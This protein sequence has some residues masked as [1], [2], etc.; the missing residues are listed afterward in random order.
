MKKV[1]QLFFLLTLFAFASCKGPKGD[2]GVAGAIGSAGPQGIQG[3]MGPVGATGN[4]NIKA[5]IFSSAPTDWTAVSSTSNGIYYQAAAAVA[6]ITQA[7]H[8]KG[9]VLGF[10]SEGS[11][12]SVWIAMPYTQVYKS[13]SLTYSQ[14]YRFSEKVGSI[15][16]TRQDSDGLTLASTTT[17]YFKFVII[18]GA[19]APP[20]N[21]DVNSYQAVKDFY[22]IAD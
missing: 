16:V 9:L 4:A 5:R 17:K 3:Q 6:E 1:F 19:S 8:D 15:T 11:D 20:P 7:I 2:A 12:Q 10:V 21:L 18:E 13:T 14:T 22:H